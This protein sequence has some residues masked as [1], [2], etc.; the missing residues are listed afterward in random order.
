MV[1]RESIFYINLRHA[2]LLS[3]NYANRIFSRTVLFT[4]VPDAYLDEVKLLKAFGDAV[5]R[6][7][8]TMSILLQKKIALYSRTRLKDLTDIVR[9]PLL[10]Q[11]PD[12]KEGYETS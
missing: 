7:W 6:V 10:N 4:S 8:I 3:P 5:D 12:G 11:L 1:C 2:L 9:G